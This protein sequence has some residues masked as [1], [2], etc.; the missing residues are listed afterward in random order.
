MKK[1]FVI[2][3][4]MLLLFACKSKKK[5]DYFPVISFINSQVKHVD[6]SLYR[7][8]KVV[9][10]DSTSDT[11]FIRREDFRALAKDFLES[12]DLTRYS[13]GKKYKEEKFYDQS[14]NR[15]IFTYTPIKNNVEVLSEQVTIAPT[16]SGE[17]EVKSIIIEKMKE[18]DGSMLHQRLLWQVDES[19]Q[20]VDIIEK[21]GK[22]VSTK[23]TEV[24][25]NRTE[26]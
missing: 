4:A 7:I 23:K 6:T 5:N 2:A 1:I 10:V 15:V 18:E 25:W 20:V 17:D 14:L 24:I 19:F 21:N 8:I 3:S 26:E 11:T 16:L 13:I 12:P 9:T 22:P